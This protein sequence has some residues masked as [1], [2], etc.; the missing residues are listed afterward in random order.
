MVYIF[1]L[2]IHLFSFVTM[3]TMSM[4]VLAFVYLHVSHALFLH[5]SVICVS[6]Q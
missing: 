4:S 5:D 3:N 6:A 2:I 1:I